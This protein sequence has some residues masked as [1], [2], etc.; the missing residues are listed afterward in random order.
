[1]IVNRC[2]L[3]IALSLLV[4][5]VLCACNNTY[6]TSYADLP[7]GKW[8]SRD[9]LVFEVPGDPINDT[10]VVKKTLAA[11]VRYTNAYKYRK[12][13][14]GVDFCSED[15]KVIKKDTLTFELF[16]KNGGRN[17]NGTVYLESEEKSFDVEMTP[18]SS[19]VLRVYHLMRLDPLEGI[20]NVV[21]SLYDK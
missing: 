2:I 19:N 4:V 10:R 13:S 14:L 21:I 20:S 3:R 12:V 1:M 8:D 16:D 5:F 17:G 11:R 18:S 6:F 15:G 9:T 7:E